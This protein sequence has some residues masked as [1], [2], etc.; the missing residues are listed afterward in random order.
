MDMDRFEETRDRLLQV[1]RPFIPRVEIRHIGWLTRD[2]AAKTATTI[3]IE[4]S[5]PEDANKIIDEGLIWQGEV[6]QCERYERQCRVKQCFK[7]QHYGHIETQCKATIACGYCAQEHK[8]RDC[9]SRAGQTIVGS[10]PPQRRARSVEL[11]VPY[12]EGGEGESKG[13][14][15]RTPILPPSPGDTKEQHPNGDTGYH[16]PKKQARPGPFIDAAGTDLQE[17]IADRTRT[18]E[19]QNRNYRWC[20]RATQPVDTSERQSKAA[21][22]HHPHPE[23]HGSNRE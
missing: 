15:W 16:C 8:T 7:W 20:S 11:P 18:E 4:F 10:V 6:F 21:K 9:P 5:R 14:I 2:A 19:D 1:N 13:C 12:Q 17:S 22:A 3:T 23:G